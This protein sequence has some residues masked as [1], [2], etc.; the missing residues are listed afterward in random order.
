M[1]KNYFGSLKPCLVLER[2]HD[3]LYMHIIQEIILNYFAKNNFLCRTE[4]ITKLILF[5][6]VE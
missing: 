3:Q 4:K 1:M 5:Y 6:V 2:N